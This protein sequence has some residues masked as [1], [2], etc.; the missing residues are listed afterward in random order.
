ML[1]DHGIVSLGQTADEIAGVLED[2][3]CALLICR[4][5]DLVTIFVD[6]STSLENL[7]QLGKVLAN[8]APGAIIGI[9]RS[10]WPLIFVP[11]TASSRAVSSTIHVVTGEGIATFD[12]ASINGPIVNFH[13]TRSR[14]KGAT[15]KVFSIRNLVCAVIKGHFMADVFLLSWALGN[16][17]AETTRAVGVF[18]L[19]CE[20]LARWTYALRELWGMFVT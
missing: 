13:V 5:P 10:N 3:A 11:T 20:A 2:L 4:T 19:V 18:S 15:L 9:Q 7:R 14:T 1:V 16:P 17:N 8:L 6:G 12:I